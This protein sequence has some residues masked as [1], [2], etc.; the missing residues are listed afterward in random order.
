MIQCPVC[1]GALRANRAHPASAANPPLTAEQLY[2]RMR[3]R[4]SPE[5]ETLSSVQRAAWERLCHG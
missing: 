2:E 3:G 4:A 5:W 1:G